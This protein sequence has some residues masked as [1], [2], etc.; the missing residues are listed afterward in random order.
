M[1]WGRLHRRIVDQPMNADRHMD[2]WHPAAPQPMTMPMSVVYVS[3]DA[4]VIE[5]TAPLVAANGGAPIPAT[6]HGQWDQ[7]HALR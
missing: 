4:T 1:A 6:G 2:G 3:G 5:E 7:L